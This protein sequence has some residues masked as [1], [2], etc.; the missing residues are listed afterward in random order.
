MD[1]NILKSPK[2]IHFVFVNVGAKKM[3][4]IK[5]ILNKIES[6]ILTT[7]RINETLHVSVLKYCMNAKRLVVIGAPTD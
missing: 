4:I 1:W 7:G 5:K 6:I 2:Q 3:E